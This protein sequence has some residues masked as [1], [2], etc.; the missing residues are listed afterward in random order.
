M[1]RIQERV[2]EREWARD[3]ENEEPKYKRRIGKQTGRNRSRLKYRIDKYIYAKTK[4]Q[5]KIDI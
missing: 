5:K 2:L 3:K 1:W 4:N